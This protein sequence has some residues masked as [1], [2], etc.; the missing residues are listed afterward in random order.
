MNENNNN[1]T[2]YAI[3]KINLTSCRLLWELSFS[4]YFLYNLYLDCIF[5]FFESITLYF[6]L[7]IK[8]N[9]A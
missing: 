2:M 8:K 3:D 7:N 9:Y 6:Y 1:I 5:K 4:L